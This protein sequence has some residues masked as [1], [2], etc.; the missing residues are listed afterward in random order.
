M[1]DLFSNE[2]SLNHGMKPPG[3]L[4]C[5]TGQFLVDRKEGWCTI[6]A[7]IVVPLLCISVR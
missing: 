3:F 1:P 6:W 2:K 7:V 4:S 5:W